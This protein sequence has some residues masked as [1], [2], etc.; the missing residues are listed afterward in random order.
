MLASSFALC[1]HTRMI[2]TRSSGRLAAMSSTTSTQ[3]TTANSGKR[4]AEIDAQEP[5]ENRTPKKKK[6][7][8]PSTSQPAAS[9]GPIGTPDADNEKLVPAELTFSF[10][11]AKRALCLVGVAL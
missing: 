2:R 10:V 3:A 7:S 4:K 6:G 11:E 5:Q 9:T 8:S 1:K